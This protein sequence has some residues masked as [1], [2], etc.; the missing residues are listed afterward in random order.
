[1][2]ANLLLVPHIGT[3]YNMDRLVGAD[4]RHCV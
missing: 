2:I 1:M 4:M 3:Q